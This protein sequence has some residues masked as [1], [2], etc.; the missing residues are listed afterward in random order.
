MW[1][2]IHD[3]RP[4]FDLF[5]NYAGWIPE[6]IDLSE[7]ADYVKGKHLVFVFGTKDE[8][9]TNDRIEMLQMIIERSGL[10]IHIVKYNGN[11]SI[12]RDVIESILMNQKL[13]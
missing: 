6:D 1:R 13:L 7:L 9:L 8:Y 5:I 10:D 12:D 3:Q 11:H 4:D 2:W